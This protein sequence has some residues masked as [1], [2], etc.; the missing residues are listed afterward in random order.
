VIR[1]LL[2]LGLVG[3]LTWSAGAAVTESVI[4][5]GKLSQ[6][7]A[8]GRVTTVADGV[9]AEGIGTMVMSKHFFTPDRLTVKAVLQ[10]ATTDQG[11]AAGIG[12]GDLRFGFDN[13][14]RKFFLENTSGG[15]L[16]PLGNTADFVQPGK[17]F[18]FTATVAGG[19]I[20]V[21]IDGRT[22]C[23]RPFEADGKLFCSLRPHRNRM[24]VREFSVTGTPDGENHSLQETTSGLKLLTPIY[25][26][27]VDIQADARLE[28][29]ANSGLPVG[30][31]QLTIAPIDQPSASSA[32]PA[33]VAIVPRGVAVTLPAAGLSDAWRKSKLTNNA[34]PVQLRFAAAGKTVYETRLLLVNRQGKTDFPSGKVARI[35]GT[36]S[37][38]IDGTPMGTIT[39]VESTDFDTLQH[40]SRTVRDFA[41]AGARG[42]LLW[43]EP[44]EF[45]HNGQLDDDAFLTRLYAAL[46][47]IVCDHPDAVIDLH[48]KLYAPPEW[49]E[50]YPEEMIKLDNGIQSLAMAPKQK[51]Q[52]SYASPKWRQELSAHLRST[53]TKLRQSPFADRIAILRLG[54]A[55]CGEWNGWGAHEQAFV[56]YSLPMQ[57]AF[58][59]WLKKT[60]GNVAAL[61]AAWHNPQVSFDSTDLVPG[62][63]ARMS[64]P[65]LLRHHPQDRPVVDYYRFFQLYT[66]ETIEFFAIAAK[67]VSDSRLLVGAYYNYYTGHYNAGPYHFQDS[68]SY[69][70]RRYLDSPYL[71]FLGGPY[72]YDGRRW[73][74]DVNGVTGSV[75][76][77]NKVWESENDQRTNR[78]GAAEKIYGAPDTLAESI[79][80]AKRDFMINL[81]RQASYYYFDFLQEWFRD[82]KYMAAVTRLK[83]IDRMAMQT[84]RGSRAQ[85]ACILSDEVIPYFGNQPHVALAKLRNGIRG[86]FNRIGAP[87]DYYVDGDLD[88][89]NFAPYKVVIFANSYYASDAV[90]RQV[91]A[92]VANN[93][94]VL[95]FLYAP[96]LVNPKGYFDGNRS[97]Q[98][99]GIDLALNPDGVFTRINSVG[100][101]PYIVDNP[102]MRFQTFIRDPQ[103]KT[104]AVYPDGKVA[105]AMKTFPNYTSVLLC[106]PAPNAAWLRVWLRRQG[107]HV[108]QDGDM[109][110]DHYYFAGPFLSINSNVGGPR[111]FTLPAKAE[112]IVDLFTGEI[113]GQNTNKFSF[114]MPE[115]TPDTMIFYA[116]PRQGYEKYGPR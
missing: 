101:A 111:S 54:Y 45:S 109:I 78:S 71:D 70:L 105:G 106:H 72:P 43:V 52:P 86:W 116:G 102:P 84:G 103:A 19:K 37:F 25:S 77:H 75:A 89:I 8:T 87:I 61:R 67:Q 47:R 10:L 35:G 95:L 4:A 74:N 32:L 22:A 79:A 115:K 85:I 31:Y 114:K 38:V 2:L 36:P 59:Q 48:W 6:G 44:G 33:T 46:N 42:N 30:T 99:T 55:N 21:A 14:D 24:L 65:G 80:I 27:P 107:V 90:I 113:L 3:W 7:I 51:L 28:L 83:Q 112:V 50:L 91:K 88:R 20:T 40:R 64:E 97:R 53:L 76:L 11:S 15:D 23:I 98:L 82:A 104:I 68:G 16:T 12:I 17:W 93:R 73:E 92:R 96:G 49:S 34:R 26:V 110:Y 69:A 62:R 39:S 9:S 13:R 5:Q 58:G 56:D 94:R 1:H 81:E 100:M 63:A 57:R 60:Y 18:E 29:S 41:A 66:V 108:Y